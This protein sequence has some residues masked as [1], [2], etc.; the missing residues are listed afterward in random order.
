MMDQFLQTHIWCNQGFNFSLFFSRL[1]FFF[2]FTYQGTTTK[3]R[4][5]DFVNYICKYKTLCLAWSLTFTTTLLLNK[6]SFLQ[7]TLYRYWL[8]FL[9]YSLFF[10]L[11][12]LFFLFLFFIFFFLQNKVR[13]KNLQN[14]HSL[15]Y[16]VVSHLLLWQLPMRPHV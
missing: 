9:S 5:I 8:V 13:K 4:R 2:S 16:S 12:F 11:I 15:H 6:N 7:C 10:F 1:F 14:W 3:Y